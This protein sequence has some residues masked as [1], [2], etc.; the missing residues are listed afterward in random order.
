[1]ILAWFW[2]VYTL[3]VEQW[4]CNFLSALGICKF[5]LA[6]QIENREPK[7]AAYAAQILQPL[8]TCCCLLWFEFSCSWTD[9]IKKFASIHVDLYASNLQQT[10]SIIIE[11]SQVCWCKSLLSLNSIYSCCLH[12][13]FW[14]ARHSIFVSSFESTNCF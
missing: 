10:R 5:L 11:M 7:I 4:Q 12:T 3:K 13:F 1:M 14:R 2:Q 6:R 8:G 9:C